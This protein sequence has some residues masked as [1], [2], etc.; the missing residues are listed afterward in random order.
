ME[1]PARPIISPFWTAHDEEARR[2]IAKNFLRKL[3][4]ERI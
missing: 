2:N 1:V 3:K 4:G